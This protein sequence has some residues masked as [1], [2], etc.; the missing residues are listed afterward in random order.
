MASG[1]STNTFLPASRAWHTNL[2]WVSWRVAMTSVLTAGLV[3]SE[4]VSVVACS[5]PNLR[6]AWTPLTPPAV[7]TDLSVAAVFLKA[8]MRTWVA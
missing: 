5:M 2:A 4:A 1:F 7:D 8:G 6:A 3:N